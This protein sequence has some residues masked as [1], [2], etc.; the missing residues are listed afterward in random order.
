MGGPLF[1]SISYRCI[2]GSTCSVASCANGAMC[3]NNGSVDHCYCTA[4]YTGNF[5]TERTVRTIS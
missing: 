3:V 4:G 1:C 2:G 5:C